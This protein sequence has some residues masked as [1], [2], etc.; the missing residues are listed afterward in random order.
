VTV[1]PSRYKYHELMPEIGR[2]GQKRISQ[3]A[4]AVIGLGALGSTCSMLLARAGV[5]RLI[6]FEDDKVELSNLQRQL[7]YSEADIG[8]SKAEL[9]KRALHRANSEVVIKAVPQKLSKINIKLL[10][11]GDVDLVADCTDNLMARFVL[12]DFC[13]KNK[14][15][16]VHAACLAAQGQVFCIMPNRAC[17]RC[18]FEGATAGITPKQAGVLNSCPAATA[19]LQASQILRI[20]TGKEPVNG[21]IRVDVWRCEVTRIEVKKNTKC[22]ACGNK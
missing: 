17:F 5:G 16:L 11:K 3:A 7:L 10:L 13:V 19:A 4:V 20:L 1:M 21:L 22:K 12:N 8:K 15:P 18:L 6:L 2:E 14:L 9:A